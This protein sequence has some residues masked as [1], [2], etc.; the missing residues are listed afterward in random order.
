MRLPA[1]ILIFIISMTMNPTFAQSP[2][3][4]DVIAEYKYPVKYVE[5][6][7]NMKMAYVDE[8]QGEQTLLFIHGLAT[9][10]PS[11]YNNI[12]ALKSKYRCI[13][14][15]L[16]GYGQSS[17]GTA[18]VS[19]EGYATMVLKFITKL[20]L[21]NVVLVGHSMGGQVA[22]KTVLK[23]PEQFEKLILLAPAG[24]ET[25]KPEQATWLKSVFTVESVVQATEEQIRAN[26]ALNFYQMPEDVEFMI[27]D[28][29]NLTDAQDFNLYCQAVVGG[30]HAMLDEPIYDQLQNIKQKTLVVYGA[31]DGLIPNKYLNPTLTTQQVGEKGAA[32]ISNASLKFIPS[33]GHFISF[34]KPEEIN[35]ILIEFLSK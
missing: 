32:Q 13:A 34:D 3:V 25:F 7:A 22:V 1:T 17:K 35:E 18:K 15:D 27:Q 19:M 5:V 11:W 9:Y 33:C 29:L 6:D 14:I 31:N 26:W 23:D 4:S 8:G 10:L 24:F 2:K 12:G 28:R 20:Q 21:K 16:P 30:M